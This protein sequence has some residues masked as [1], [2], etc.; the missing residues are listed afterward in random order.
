MPI[1]RFRSVAEMENT[2]WLDRDDPRL[3][4]TIV[5][6]WD[7]SARLCPVHFPPGLHKHHSIEEANRQSEEWEAANVLRSN[8]R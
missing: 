1:R 8:P 3:W 2:V 6:V 4:P 7:L 5:S